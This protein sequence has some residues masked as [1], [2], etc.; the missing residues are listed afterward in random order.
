M[1]S[2]SSAPL[3]KTYSN[4]KDNKVCINSIFI[5]QSI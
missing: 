4:E 3:F 5:K 1:G 2:G